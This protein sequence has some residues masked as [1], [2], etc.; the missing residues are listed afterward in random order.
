MWRLIAGITVAAA[1]LGRGGATQTSRPLA[2]PDAPG[3]SAFLKTCSECHGPESAVAQL[4]TPDE[5]RKTVDEMAANGAQ[6][7]DD[8]WNDILSYLDS[9]FS[10]ILVNKADGKILAKALG[11][12]DAEG[13][14]VVRYRAEHG[15]FSTIEDLKNVPGLEAK[16]IDSR[17]DRLVF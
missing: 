12:P 5:W 14:A 9:Y 15:A 11:V 7:T 6:A 3:K 2:L 17:K 13:E 4:K 8:E 16:T 1:V 10:L